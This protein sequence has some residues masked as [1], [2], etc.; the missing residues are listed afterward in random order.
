VRRLAVPLVA[1][2]VLFGTTACDLS[3]PG[4]KVVEPKPEGETVIGKVPQQKTVE[5]PQQFAEG[6]PAAG[7][8][9]FAANCTG[10]HTLKAAGS[11]GNVGPNLDQA[12][13]ELTLIV[14]RVL[15]GQGGMP[16][17]EGQLETEQIRDVAAY[18]YDSTHGNDNSG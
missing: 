1:L 7:K 15:K 2:L 6:D 10:C 18:V 5:V 4:R 3:K 14:Q 11:T 9:V 12:K 17:F 13:P 16:P 8:T